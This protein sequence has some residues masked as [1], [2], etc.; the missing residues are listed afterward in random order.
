MSLSATSSTISDINDVKNAQ[1]SINENITSSKLP[2]V[3]SK[4]LCSVSPEHKKWFEHRILHHNKDGDVVFYEEKRGKLKEFL[5]CNSVMAVAS[6]EGVKEMHPNG[7]AGLKRFIK[8]NT[9]IDVQNYCFQAL[10][11]RNL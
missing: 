10:K 6:S 2:I 4:N 5:V 8:V 7:V 3:G 11:K 1:D 9:P